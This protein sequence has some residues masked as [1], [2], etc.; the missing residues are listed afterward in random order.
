MNFN[1]SVAI[2]MATYNGSRY[3]ARQM[4]SL[5]SQTTSDWVLLIRDDGSTD[6][7]VVIVK[8][9]QEAHPGKIV[10]VE[11][12]QKN[13]GPRDN[14]G[15][16]IESA[17]TDYL[18]FCDQDD[19]WLPDKIERTLTKMQKLEQEFG[20]DIPL[21]VHTDMTVADEDLRPIAASFWEY[22]KMD[23][24]RGEH[25]QRI[26]I[27]NVANGCTVMINRKLREMA[28]PI[29]QGAIMH[30]WWLA[31]IAAAFGKVDYITEQT[32]LYRVHSR[33]VV[34]ASPWSLNYLLQKLIQVH[35]RRPLLKCLIETGKQA[36]AF[37]ARFSPLLSAKNREKVRAYAELLDQGPIKKRFYVIK[38]GF[39]RS[40]CIRNAS[41]LLRM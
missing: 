24:K 8:K 31:L 7:T 41:L 32:V 29:P 9:Y 6:E 3:V 22:Q 12:G 11:D 16:L 20:C 17:E 19:V 23:P 10:V 27:G 35:D 2:A 1:S 36:E 15:R 37:L 25:F 13:L 33:N 34:G 40:G 21:L 14:F 39:F 30:D 18:M 26:F 28:L 4:D 38:H 5:F